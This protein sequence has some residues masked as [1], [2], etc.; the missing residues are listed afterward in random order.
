MKIHLVGGFL[1]SGKT[2]AIMNA[3]KKYIQQGKRAGII[4]NDQGKYLVDTAFFSL[5]QIPAVEVTGGCFCCNYHQLDDQ[6]ENLIESVQ[7]DVI[8]AESVGS[9][10]DLVATV[11]RPLQ[12]LRKVDPQNTSFSVFVDSRLLRVRLLD[13]P[14]PFSDDVVYIF[15]KQIEEAGLVILNKKDLLSPENQ[16]HLLESFQQ[17]Y[18]DKLCILQNS[19]DS[20]NINNWLDLIEVKGDST[21]KNSMD[22]NYKK[23]GDGE[24]LLAWVDEE[25]LLEFPPQNTRIEISNI[26]QEILNRLSQHKVGIGHLKVLVRT[27]LGAEKISFPAFEQPGWQA[28]IP[29]S[30]DGKVTILLNARVEMPVEELKALINSVITTHA[31]EA[32]IINPSAF[33]PKAPKPTYRFPS[34]ETAT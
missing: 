12:Q 15:D 27:N 1:G 33:H 21:P 16:V 26:I 17:V 23:Y 7:P 4:T 6:L 13:E 30:T 8:F 19:L 25:I 34:P 2:T 9:C 10:A 28:R 3:A 22:I 18:P 14:M 24:A 5:N 31:R 20:E 11:V 32:S 29:E